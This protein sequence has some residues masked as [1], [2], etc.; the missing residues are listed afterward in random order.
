MTRGKRGGDA[1]SAVSFR[2]HLAEKL[3]AVRCTSQVIN[4]QGRRSCRPISREGNTVVSEF[5]A[6]AT[7]IQFVF[8]AVIKNAKKRIAL[9]QNVNPCNIV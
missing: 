1:K 2:L 7:V 6:S 4:K 5:H 8:P 9:M 3:K